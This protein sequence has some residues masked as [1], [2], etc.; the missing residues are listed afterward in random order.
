MF[1]AGLGPKIMIK[2]RIFNYAKRVI[3]INLYVF[4]RLTVFKILRENYFLNG[5][6]MEA[7]FYTFNTY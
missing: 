4:L 3:Q 5:G 2:C 6:H 1:L 7:E